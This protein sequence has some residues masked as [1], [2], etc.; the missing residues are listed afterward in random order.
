MKSLNDLAAD[1][2]ASR[3]WA[4]LSTLRSDQLGDDLKQMFGQ[5]TAGPLP[6]RI[7]QLADA[8]EEAFRRGDLVDPDTRRMS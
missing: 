4:P 3:P 5:L 7:V 8:L 2:S 6:D 1:A